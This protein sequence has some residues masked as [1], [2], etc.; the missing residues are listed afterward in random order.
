MQ[1]SFRYIWILVVLIGLYLGWTY[2]SRWSDTHE[3]MQTIEDSQPSR[4]RPLS[5]FYSSSLSILNFYAIPQTI[6]TGET[7]QLCY[8]VES[9]ESVRIEP[10]VGKVWPSYTLCVDISPGSDTVYK[11]IA[12]DADGNK[13]TAEAEIKVS[14]D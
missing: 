9:A 7:A 13:V 2:Y 5:D 6:R 4:D 8:G 11:L 10:P 14:Q 1:K 3:F 12:E